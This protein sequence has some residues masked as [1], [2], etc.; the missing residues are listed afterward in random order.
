MA[1]PFWRGSKTSATLQTNR[2]HLLSHV[3]L[4]LLSS[5][6]TLGQNNPDPGSVRQ[7][8]NHVGGALKCV[9]CNVMKFGFFL[10]EE[11]ETSAT[12]KLTMSTLSVLGAHW[13]NIPT[14]KYKSGFSSVQ[15]ANSVQS[16]QVWTLTWSVMSVRLL[17]F[18]DGGS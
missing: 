18:K 14:C 17:N 12:L 10:L 6:C 4:S 11:I 3:L 5:Q 1:S 9:Q 16:S 2:V 13:S 8:P 7:T 15:P